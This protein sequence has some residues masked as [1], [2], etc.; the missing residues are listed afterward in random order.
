MNMGMPITNITLKNIQNQ[1]DDYKKDN[2][3]ESVGFLNDGYHSFNDLYKHRL[4]LT[5]I[6]FMYL[7]YAWKSKKHEDGDMFDGMF[8]VGAP[9]P[10]GMITYHYDL[11]YWDLFKVPELPHAPHFDGHTPDDV[12]DR[13]MDYLKSSTTRLV[14]NNNIDTIESIVKEEILPVFENPVL[15]ASFVA[16]YNK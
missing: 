3:E 12:L 4:L 9:T 2:P 15:A 1:I 13:L 8:I 5:A 10:S 11:P 16:F 14:N 7:P 6:A